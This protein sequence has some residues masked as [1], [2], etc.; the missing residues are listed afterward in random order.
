MDALHKRWW[1]ILSRALGKP[2][3]VTFLSAA[4]KILVI[5]TAFITAFPA[6]NLACLSSPLPTISAELVLRKSDC[7]EFISYEIFEGFPPCTPSSKRC[8]L[9][10]IY[11][12]T[13]LP[14]WIRWLT[15]QDW[16]HF[17][18]KNFQNCITDVTL[19]RGNLWKFLTNP[20]PSHIH[21]LHIPDV[22]DPETFLS[23]SSVLPF[24]SVNYIGNFLSCS[25]WFFHKAPR[26]S[27]V[28]FKTLGKF[29][30]CIFISPQGDGK[31]TTVACIQSAMHEIWSSTFLRVV[32]GF[33]RMENFSTSN[34]V[35]LPV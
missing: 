28:D 20:H 8:K 15:S 33:L 23:H 11:H 10:R 25:Q 13:K 16:M 14:A 31:W 3:G 29:F 6:L 21:F 34:R 4:S 24:G 22:A 35:S 27:T 2:L 1:G 7:P 26:V 32:A 5:S 18:M 19:K 17:R 9:L 12:L 30:F